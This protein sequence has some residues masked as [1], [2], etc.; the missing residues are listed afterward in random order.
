MGLLKLV[1]ISLIGIF[2][3]CGCKDGIW[4][5]KS[6]DDPLLADVG[7]HH[8]YA[9]EVKNLITKGTSVQDSAN[10]VNAYVQNWVRQKL[11]ED[12]AEK[13]MSAGIKISELV[14]EYRSSLL[15]YN[16]ENQL[17]NQ[18]L[19][20]IVSLDEADSYYET[21]KSQFI[22]SHPILKIIL[23][24][25]PIKSKNLGNIEKSLKKD[26]LTESFFLI[27]ENANAMNL[28]TS[29]WFTFQEISTMVPENYFNDVQFSNDKLISKKIGENQIIVKVLE[30]HS[31]NSVPPF[32]YIK[33]RIDKL[34]VSERKNTILSKYRQNLYEEGIKNKTFTIY[35]FER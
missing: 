12:E 23:A 11:I 8:L 35:P 25:V 16:Y 14:S 4:F 21:H 18:M 13:N 7:E 29:K 5:F 26:E 31:E 19:D 33:D 3:F 34:I 24:K 28:D 1:L 20:T 15:V 9:S 32:L 2:T 10:I 17:I 22:L 6:D 27:K 30:Y